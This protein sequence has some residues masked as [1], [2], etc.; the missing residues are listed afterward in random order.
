ML[1]L[2]LRLAYF[3]YSWSWCCWRCEGLSCWN[4]AGCLGLGEQRRRGT[5]LGT[6]IH[7]LCMLESGTTK[8]QINAL[9][10]P[11][12]S[13]HHD[14]RGVLIFDF[15]KLLKGNLGQINQLG[16]MDFA[17]GTQLK[18]W[19]HDESSK[20]LSNRSAPLVAGRVLAVTGQAGDFQEALR[21]AY[22]G[23]KQ[24][25]FDPPG[26]ASDLAVTAGDRWNRLG[27]AILVCTPRFDAKK[28]IP[29]LHS[30]D[31]FDI[32]EMIQKQTNTKDLQ[33][34]IVGTV[35]VHRISSFF[36]LWGEFASPG[37]K[38]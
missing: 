20:P 27:L 28:L 2:P 15:A 4:K 30:N 37:K 6:Y 33:L 36:P 22:E 29:M 18:S 16:C 32:F 3:W 23:V 10:W 5:M 38:T 21:R 8:N 25:R 14:P 17:I 19:I 1:V 31:A 9:S 13:K 11:S 24:I 35:F 34:A 7:G 12:I 26:A